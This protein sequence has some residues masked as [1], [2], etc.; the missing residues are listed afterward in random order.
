M[1][2][3]TEGNCKDCKRIITSLYL[4]KESNPVQD[5]FKDME[6]Y[7]HN[8]LEDDD[9]DTV[10]CKDDNNNARRKDTSYK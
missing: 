3:H 5:L 2:D 9:P 7:L 8:I 10:R 1:T 6:K 4:A